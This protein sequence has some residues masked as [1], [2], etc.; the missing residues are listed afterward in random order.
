MKKFLVNKKGD[1]EEVAKWALW[2]LVFVGLSAGVYFL[3]KAI[4]G[5]II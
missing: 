2:I 5:G 1:I 3:I 4:A